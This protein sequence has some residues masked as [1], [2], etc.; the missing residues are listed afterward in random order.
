MQQMDQV[1]EAD[2]SRH[3]NFANGSIRPE[4]QDDLDIGNLHNIKIL[5]QVRKSTSHPT[6]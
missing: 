5:G 6:N 1:F 4:L 2:M 3:M